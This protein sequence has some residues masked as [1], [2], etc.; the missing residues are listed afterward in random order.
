MSYIIERKKIWISGY[1]DREFKK[2]RF[3]KN[4]LPYR[5]SFENVSRFPDF[6]FFFFIE[7]ILIKLLTISN[8]YEFK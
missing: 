5:K 4:T 7:K 2:N 8:I 6:H 1:L 3:S